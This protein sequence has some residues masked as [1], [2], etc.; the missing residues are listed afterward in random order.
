[1]PDR[2][3]TSEVVATPPTEPRLPG[4][5]TTDLAAVGA[6]DPQFPDLD[7]AD[8][9]AVELAFPDARILTVLRSRMRDCEIEVGERRLDAQDAVLVDLDLTG[10]RIDGLTR[11]RFER[12]RLA[13]ADFAES[14]MQDV[15]FDDCA[16][17]LASMRVAQLERVV[18]SGGRADELDLTG[19]RLRDVTLTSVP[20]G[21]ILLDGTGLDRVDLT[22][23][24]LDGVVDLAV[25]KGA[26]ISPV[27]AAGLAARLARA[28]G[29]HVAPP[30]G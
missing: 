25:L 16:L 30:R 21:P 28:A 29:L 10:W 3:D 13:G 14:R 20:V 22:E 4:V 26:T 8:L 1:M 19:A 18:V 2:D 11:V 27:Q 15:T 17:E 7:G 5:L 9:H 12:C 24:E 6:D 23:A